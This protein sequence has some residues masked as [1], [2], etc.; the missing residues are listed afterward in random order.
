M[1]Y[2][3]EILQKCDI[4]PEPVGAAARQRYGICSATQNVYI[5]QQYYKDRLEAEALC[6]YQN[7]IADA[8]EDRAQHTLWAVS[9]H[10]KMTYFCCGGL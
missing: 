2:R 8:W 4:K 1:S 9:P 5:L 3:R 7:T 10:S 6:S